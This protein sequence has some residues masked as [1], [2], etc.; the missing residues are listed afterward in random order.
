M[1]ACEPRN[2]VVVGVT[3]PLDV[4]DTQ[5]IRTNRI[6]TPMPCAAVQVHNVMLTQPER[7][8]VFEMR[9]IRKVNV[10]GSDNYIRV[11]AHRHQRLGVGVMAVQE[12]A[13][14]RAVG[15]EREF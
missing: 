12:L 10:G 6:W 15:R 1:I 3:T 14:R 4:E 11:A 13:A 5:R 8:D 7:D 2:P 9:R